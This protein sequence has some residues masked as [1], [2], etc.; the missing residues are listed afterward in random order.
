VVDRPPAWWGAG[1]LSNALCPGPI[2]TDGGATT[3]CLP[4]AG[5]IG[6][7]R[8]S[9]AARVGTGVLHWSRPARDTQMDWGI[10]R[11]CKSVFKLIYASA[12]ISRYVSMSSDSVS[13]CAS[14][15]ACV[16]PGCCFRDICGT[17]WRSFA[18][19][20]SGWCFLGDRWTDSFWGYKGQ[21]SMP[22]LTAGNRIFKYDDVPM[23]LLV[24]QIHVVQK[25]IHGFMTMY[26]ISKSPAIVADAN[27]CRKSKMAA[28]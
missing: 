7:V 5:A 3:V 6:R 22:P 11:T 24:L 20:L 23:T 26:E 13:V 19:L 27:P 15:H 1:L 12:T 8:R 16:P 9:T 28:N 25:I 14:V 4:P 10:A 18:K 21:R 2:D 17:H